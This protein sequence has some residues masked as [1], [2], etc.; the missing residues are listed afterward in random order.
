MR[1]FLIIWAGQLVSLLGTGM[2]RFALL[3]WAW[4]QKSEA[5]TL[6]LLGFFS[7]GAYVVV[8]PFAGVIVDRL[9]RRLVMILA[10]LGAGLTTVGLLLLFST[11]NLHI[12]HLYLAQVVASVCEAFQVP[13]S[14]PSF[15]KRKNSLSHWVKPRRKK[16]VE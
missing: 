11:G 9:D 4:Q 12:W 14:S 8:S 15:R 6:A 16:L 3:I 5:T 13:A 2:T 10:D 7:Y 1:T